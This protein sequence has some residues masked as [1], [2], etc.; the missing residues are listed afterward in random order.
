MTI[1]RVN[2]PGWGSGDELTFTQANG[3]D[4]NGTYALDK[5]AANTD[6]LSSVV[7][8][9]GS[10]RVID[11]IASGANA[12]TTYVVDAANRVIQVTTSVGSDRAYTLSATGAVAG[13]Q[14]TIFCDAGFTRTITVKDQAAATMCLLGNAVTSHGHWA[15]FIYSSGWRLFRYSKKRLTRTYVA[16]DTLVVPDNV[17]AMTFE[18]VGGG[19]GGGGG[20]GAG[21]NGDCSAPGGGG[22]RRGRVE[23]TVVPG[24]TLTIVCGAGGG[25]GAGG[26]SGGATGTSGAHGAN[27]T[28]T[29]SSSGLLATFYG[30]QGAIFATNTPGFYLG[31]M[32]VAT[33][34]STTHGYPANSTSPL[35]VGGG[36]Y[37]PLL[38]IPGQGGMAG[39][40]AEVTSKFGG[41]TAYA[42]G[43]G[44]V[45]TVDGTYAG[46]GGASEWAGGVGGTGGGAVN[47]FTHGGN[48]G[49]G[50]YGSGGGGGAGGWTTPTA[51]GNGG[52]GGDGVVQ[53]IW[54]VR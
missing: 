21:G 48:G 9:A 5:R 49:N 36:Y 41:S 6:T 32:P 35:T 27:T 50:I 42:L 43:G 22:A 18:G 34:G 23:C 51:G 17:I 39:T 1:A 7:S 12:D 25:G 52:T 38:P 15:T 54:E 33:Q 11:T 3:L 10:G 8:L 14:I 20:R 45:S 16:N 26:S 19:G 31:G 29:G 40:V 28:V 44:G 37:P 46:S 4:L 13:D 47:S 30:A 24:E 2:G 53:A